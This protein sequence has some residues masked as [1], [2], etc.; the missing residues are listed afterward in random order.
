MALLWV[1]GVVMMR[2]ATADRPLLRRAA[3]PKALYQHARPIRGY[4]SFG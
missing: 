1:P 2:Q 4:G 3:G